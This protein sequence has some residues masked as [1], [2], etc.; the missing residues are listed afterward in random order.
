VPQATL[1]GSTVG[2]GVAAAQTDAAATVAMAIGKASEAL[3][4]MAFLS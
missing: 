1:G 4:V 2:H 3:K